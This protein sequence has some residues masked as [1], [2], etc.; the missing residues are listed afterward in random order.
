MIKLYEG[1]LKLNL[2]ELD[3]PNTDIDNQGL[4][5]NGSNGYNYILRRKMKDTTNRDDNSK[6]HFLILISLS[7]L[8]L[9]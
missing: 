9:I 8:A 2:T 4:V 3:I 5:S 7:F 1:N 6:I